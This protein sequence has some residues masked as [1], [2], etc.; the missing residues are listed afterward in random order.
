[1]EFF[2]ADM[3]PDGTSKEDCG[4]GLSVEKA[5]GVDAIATRLRTTF[6]DKVVID[7]QVR[8]ISAGDIPWYVAAAVDAG[9]PE[10][11]ETWIM[12]VN[13]SYLAAMHPG[14]IVSHPLSREQ[15]LSW[16]FLPDRL[17]DAVVGIRAALDSVELTQRA[18]E[19]ELIGWSVH[20]ESGGFSAKGPDVKLEVLPAGSR[21]GIQQVDLRLQRSVPKTTI[22]LGSAQLLLDGKSGKLIFKKSD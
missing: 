6:G 9:R 11:I 17:L 20:R 16:N 13:P 2:A 12:E 8:T 5:G 10:A 21:A 3:L 14:S 15:Y 1:M 18:D 4:V 19:L 22:Q 7:K